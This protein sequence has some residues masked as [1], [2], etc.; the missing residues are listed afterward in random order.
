MM[1][2]SAGAAEASATTVIGFGN[3][4]IDNACTNTGTATPRGATTAGPGAL[5]ALAVA[6]PVG[7]PSNGCGDLGAKAGAVAGGVAGYL[8]GKSPS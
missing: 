5:N 6:L 1:L 7:S 2:L 4:A 8:L 3:A